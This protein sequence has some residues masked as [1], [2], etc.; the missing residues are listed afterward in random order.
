MAAFSEEFTLCGLLPGAGGDRFS[1]LQGVENGGDPDRVL[2]TD[3]ARAVTVYKV[4]DQ[5]PLGSWTVKQGQQITCPA[6]FNHETG[7]YIVV[8][9]QKVLRIWKDDDVNLEKVFK[10]TLSA[11]VCR[12][13]TL[14]GA[15]PLVVFKG[16][17]VQF[18]DSLLADPQQE[19]KS[20]LTAGEQ[21]LCSKMF[22]EAGR[23]VLVYITQKIQDYFVHIWI[24]SPN[25]HRTYKLKAATEEYSAL[26][27]S[28]SL[29]NQMLTLLILYSNS[30]VGHTSVSL[31]QHEEMAEIPL[32]MSPL[33]H[34]PEP[35][36]S[37]AV[38]ILDDSHLAVLTSASKQ[39]G[40][41]S[42]WNTTF[43]TIQ[44]TREF[45]QKTSTQLWC[46]DGKLYLQHGKALVVVPYSCETSCLASALGKRRNIQT[47]LENVSIVNWESYIANE[48]QSKQLSTKK[49]SRQK[50]SKEDSGDNAEVTSLLA[51]IKNSPQ[52]Q[53]KWI[54]RKGLVDVG[55]AD[56]QITVC[57]VALE[58]MNRCK[59]DPQFYPQSALVQLI[60]TNKLSYSLCPDMVF[61]ALKNQDVCLLQLCL[62]SFPDVPEPILC[63]CLKTF[64]SVA[65]DKLTEVEIDVESAVYY[66]DTIKST[67][68]LE[69]PE[70]TALVQNGFSPAVLEED[71]CDVQI[72]EKTPE[73]ALLPIPPVTVKRAAL[74]NSVLTSAYSETFL[75]PHLK[76]LS[77]EQ[78]ILLLRYLH[79]L[80]VKC[81]EN[82]TVDL[83]GKD[84]PSVTQIMDWMS[85]LLDAHFTVVVMLPEAKK[86][87]R[88]L[89]KFVR[90]Q[91]KFYSELNNIEGSLTELQKL[92]NKQ[93][94]GQYSIEVL[95]LF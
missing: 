11:D 50:K 2:V 64:L 25:F 58:L 6:V 74:L 1:G 26:S 93:D 76:D 49:N 4:S 27:F 44:V 12:V 54:L 43:Q 24:F 83:P 38:A 78:V 41:L 89:Q 48:S 7:E 52:D 31:I 57:K 55:S 95:E 72:V 17:A 15:E 28:C 67:N 29:K 22:M 92:N 10:A 56:F 39:K 86:L 59:S 69:A 82:L 73:K 20:V 36:D 94:R 77:A 23:S 79:C 88:S 9:D 13:H 32:L 21:I 84:A 47:A 80:Y 46:F 42:I 87:L 45:P 14:P 30:S 35:T 3:S 75:L 40:C 19:I 60:Q 51:D 70:E 85:L 18:L 91:V 53:I 16:G 65:E 66:I 90:S 61:I 63:S 62:R 68:E 34:L 5:K 8:H 81:N 37:G 71:S 33:L